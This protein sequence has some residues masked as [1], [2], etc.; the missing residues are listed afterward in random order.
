MALLGFAMLFAM[1][2]PDATALRKRKGTG[3]D[4]YSP[5]DGMP[6]LQLQPASGEEREAMLSNLTSLSC[7]DLM[8]NGGAEIEAICDHEIVAMLSGQYGDKLTVVQEDAGAFFRDTSGIAQAINASRDLTMND[9]FSDW[10]DLDSRLARVQDAVSKSG[11]VATWEQIGTSIENERI[12]AVRLRGRQWGS[13]GKRVVATFQ[14][15]ARE[16]ITGMVGVYTVENAINRARSDPAWLEGMELVLVPAANPDGI[17]WSETSERMFRKNRRVNSGSSCRGVDLNRNFPPDWGGRYSTSRN[18]CS[19]TFIGTSGLSEPEAQTVANLL[20]EHP[21]D[22]YLDVHS[23][24]RLILKS[25]A[26]TNTPHPRNAEL[27]VVGQLMYEATKNARGTTYRYGGNEFLGPASGCTQDY[28]P[29]D[30]GFGFTYEM[31][32][33]SFAPP[34]SDILPGCEELF[35]G[36]V[37]AVGWA[38]PGSGPAPTPPSPTPPSPTPPSPTPP[39]PTPPPPTPPTGGCEH[40]KDCSVNPWCKNTGYEAWC[41]AQGAACP[42]PFC[43]RT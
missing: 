32:G 41:R 28:L 11:G 12:M 23:Y 36:L 26:Y 27:D 9:F 31:R 37:A 18:P 4:C 5:Y 35:A 40:E 29:A 15:H 14:I 33:R 19:N 34:A 30:V 42:A 1:C 39:S 2:L 25:W 38:R 3:N 13:A 20:D 17:R 8:E 43:K 24:G 7:T 21:T 6:L 22:V 16:W 10:R